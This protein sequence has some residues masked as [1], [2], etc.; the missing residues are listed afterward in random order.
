[1]MKVSSAIV[2]AA[3]LLYLMSLLLHAEAACRCQWQ[4]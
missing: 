1:M 3:V 2:K 4:A